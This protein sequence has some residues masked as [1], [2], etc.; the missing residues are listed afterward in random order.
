[1]DENLRGKAREIIKFGKTQNKRK[2]ITQHHVFAG[3]GS[4]SYL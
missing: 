1:M 4:N 3:M 2:A